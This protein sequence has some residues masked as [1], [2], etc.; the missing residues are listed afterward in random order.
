[1]EDGEGQE[2]IVV[3]S[4][5]RKFIEKEVK[6]EKVHVKGGNARYDKE[7]HLSLQDEFI[8]HPNI[9]HNA[10][11][12]STI[13]REVKYKDIH[14][15]CLGLGSFASFLKPQL[16]MQFL[17]ICI[18]KPLELAE[19]PVTIN[20]YDPIFTS[21]EKL[22]IQNLPAT[23]NELEEFQEEKTHIVYMPHCDRFLY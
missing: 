1:M 3:R 8:N 9:I 17:K 2:W 14:V 10:T 11:I 4:K 12:I 13:L 19:L 20:I 16:Q 7:S 15:T 23:C 22:E 6:P 5:K 21:D 18:M